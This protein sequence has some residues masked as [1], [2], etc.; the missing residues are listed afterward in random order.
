MRRRFSQNSVSIGIELD[1]AELHLA[2]R[3]SAPECQAPARAVTYRW[4][5]DAKSLSS[6]DGSTELAAAFKDLTSEHKLS[7]A[8]VQLAL[9]GDYCVTHV[10]AGD[11][12]FV[13]NELKSVERRS[14][15]YFLLGAGPKSLGGCVREVDAKHQHALVGVVNQRTL[16]VLL[17]VCAR[18]GLEIDCVE[19]TIVAVCRMLGTWGYDA[20]GPVLVVD[21]GLRTAE[22]AIAHEG[23]LLLNYRPAGTSGHEQ[24][25][26]TIDRHLGRLQRYCDR[27]A[28]LKNSNISRAIVVGEPEQTAIVAK[29]IASYGRLQAIA[30]TGPRTKSSYHGETVLTSAQVAAAGACLRPSAGEELRHSPNLLDQLRAEAR[31]PLTPVL[32]R[33]LW[34]VA[35]TVLV[36]AGVWSAAYW[37]NQQC[38]ALE[39]R[40]EAE[41][42]QL[43]RARILRMQIVQQRDTIDQLRAIGEAIDGPPWGQIAQAIGQCLPDDVWLSDFNV[44]GEGRLSMTGSAHT[45]DGVFEFVEWLRR[46][47]ALR[48]VALSGTERGRVQAEP[49][50]QFN[51]ECEVNGYDEEAAGAD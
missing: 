20:E 5:H 37:Q 35:A 21:L 31:Q 17:D 15:S 27:Y 10:V 34:P 32:W 33:T 45:E 9:S 2:I 47:P 24:L 46:Y 16:K 13:R 4:R 28:R 19:P 40:L 41:E 29:Q 14:S 48:R 36:A 50:V 3:D 7:G 42:P 1:Y 49:V 25:A 51:V 12:D 8:K 11:N 18:V 38:A 23:Q 30:P 43:A 39:Q 26:E 22:V 6:D 44:D